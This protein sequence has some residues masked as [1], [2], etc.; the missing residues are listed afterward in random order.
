MARKQ[1]GKW[2]A[3]AAATGGS[4][5]Y[6]GQRPVKWYSSLVLICILGVALIWYSRY[7]RQHP[8]TTGQP[9][10]GTTWVAAFDFDICGTVEPPLPANPGVKGVGPGLTTAGDDVIHIAP[11]VASEAGAN[12]TLGRFASDYRGMVLTSTQVRY[13]GKTSAGPTVGRTFTL[14]EKCPAG[15]KYAGKKGQVE[16]DQWPTPTTTKPVS[17]GDPPALRLNDEQEITI[18]YLPKG[19][20]VPRPPG[21][22]VTAMLQDATASSTAGSG[23]ASSGASGSG[24]TSSGAA[25]SSATSSGATGSSVTSSGASGSGATSSGAAGSGATSS[26]SSGSG[27]ASSG[28]SG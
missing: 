24:A 1:T 25:G 15:T 21:K 26:G 3:R 14:G 5:S 28:S 11:H 20:P 22:A 27:A 19:A 10:V 13:P 23:T 2:V 9:A 18:A 17:V 16:V 8:S 12:A 7:E 6:R 4:R